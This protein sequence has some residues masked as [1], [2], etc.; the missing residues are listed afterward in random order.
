V[1]ADGI[2]IDLP[3][4][5]ELISHLAGAQR[6][7]VSSALARLAARGLIERS[8][9]GWLLHGDPPSPGGTAG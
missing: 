4:T 9:T 6:P 8:D 5:H 3:L 1:H 2:H 7:S